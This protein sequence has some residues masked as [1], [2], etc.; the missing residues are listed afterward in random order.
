M[1]SIGT[2]NLGSLH[3]SADQHTETW[4]Y[5]RALAIT[6]VWLFQ[7]CLPPAELEGNLVFPGSIGG[8]R[9]WG[10]AVYAP[11]LKTRSISRVEPV[12]RGQRRGQVNL[13]ATLPGCV[14]VARVHLPSGFELTCISVYGVIELGY[15]STTMHRIL[16]DLEPLFDDGEVGDAVVIGGDFNVCTQWSDPEDLKFNARDATVF[17]RLRSFGLEDCVVARRDDM[18]PQLDCACPDGK[19]CVHVRTQRHRQSQKPWQ[20][21]YLFASEWLVSEHLTEVQ[22]S[23]GDDDPAWTHSDHCPVTAI[24]DLD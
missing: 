22:V 1:L 14:A 17:A 3:G 13:L 8:Y 18:P 23:N 5:L 16:S 9:R 24:F 12:W 2:W 15:A 21:D 10:S 7:E 4:S 19:L 6:D 11:R 20:N